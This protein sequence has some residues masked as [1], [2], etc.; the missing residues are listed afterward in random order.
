M[1]RLW[2]WITALIVSIALHCY[3][4]GELQFSTETAAD[5]EWSYP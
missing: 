1:W 3:T 4:S 5:R 2:L